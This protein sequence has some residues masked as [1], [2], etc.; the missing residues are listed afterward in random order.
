MSHGCWL[1]SHIG[2]HR[3]RTVFQLPSGD[4]WWPGCLNRQNLFSH[5]TEIDI[6]LL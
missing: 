1:N 5:K 3:V 6:L 2:D 4:L